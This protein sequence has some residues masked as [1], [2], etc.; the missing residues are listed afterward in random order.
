MLAFTRNI[1]HVYG[2][3]ENF[4][5]YFSVKRLVTPIF[6]VLLLPI[7]TRSKKCWSF[8]KFLNQCTDGSSTLRCCCPY[9]TQKIN[10]QI[11]PIFTIP[12]YNIIHQSS[13]GPINHR[14][15]VS[16]RNHPYRLVFIESCDWTI[17]L[18]S[19]LYSNCIR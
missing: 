6:F 2:K 17:S 4:E 9:T 14:K 11:F 19:Y 8:I 18:K 10:K 3:H 7:C 5:L 12:E 1:A 13:I 15:C 16:L